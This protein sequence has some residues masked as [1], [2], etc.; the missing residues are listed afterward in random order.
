MQDRK[1]F[2]RR[3]VIAEYHVVQVHGAGKIVTVDIHSLF[4]KHPGAV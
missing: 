1:V 2:A 3:D 4:K